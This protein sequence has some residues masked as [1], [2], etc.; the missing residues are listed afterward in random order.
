MI[1]MKK[2]I[3]SMFAVAALGFGFA[4]CDDDSSDEVI[5][6]AQNAAVS[7]AGTYNGTWERTSTK[8]G[9]VT[10]GD[11]TITIESVSESVCTITF[12]DPASKIEASSPANVFWAGKKIYI[13]QQVGSGNDENKLGKAFTVIIQED[14]SIEASYKA[15][16]RQGLKKIETICVFS[17][18]K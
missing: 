14:G 4:S 16:I 7:A 12:S 17:G 13:N 15:E 18:K 6:H 5:K 9:S 3:Y 10:T 1:I 11:G 8:D 2:F